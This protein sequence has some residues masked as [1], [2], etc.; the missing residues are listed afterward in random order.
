MSCKIGD[1]IPSVKP[2]RQNATKT[3]HH[4]SAH[5]LGQPRTNRHTDDHS[6]SKHREDGRTSDSGDL[7][8]ALCFVV[9][10][11]SSHT[12]CE[13]KNRVSYNH[14]GTII[15]CTATT[16]TTWTIP[17]L[18]A[19]CAWALG[20]VQRCISLTLCLWLCVIC[21]CCVLCLNK[22]RVTRLPQPDSAIC[23]HVATRMYGTRCVGWRTQSCGCAWWRLWLWWW[24][25]CVV[26]SCGWFGSFVRYVYA[27]RTTVSY[28]WTFARWFC[29]PCARAHAPGWSA[30]NFSVRCDVRTT[31]SIFE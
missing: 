31:R 30:I 19:C 22:S 1:T 15:K 27:Y 14:G 20:I 29:C 24:I 5:P 25:G 10:R 17:I 11:A 12:Y 8:R 4:A 28:G 23:Q 7:T 21:W 13:Y 3:E 18:F 6:S 16:T 9:A 26:A 2:A